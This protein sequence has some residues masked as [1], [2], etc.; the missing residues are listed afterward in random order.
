MIQNKYA[1]VKVSGENR[2]VL[3]KVYDEIPNPF[4]LFASVE[5]RALHGRPFNDQGRIVV[6]SCRVV[7]VSEKEVFP[8][9]Q[10]CNQVDPG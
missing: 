2:W 8:N 1:R 7:Y 6:P 5:V 9:G 4:S 10:I 3:C